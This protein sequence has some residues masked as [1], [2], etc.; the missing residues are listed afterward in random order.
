MRQRLLVL[1]ALFLPALLLVWKL[2]YAPFWNPDE[3][4]YSSASYEMAFGLDGQKPD[5]VVPHL[6]T[7]ARLN[8]PP[9]IYW[10]TATMFRVFGPSEIAGRLPSALAAIGVLLLLFLWGR[11]AFGTWIGVAGALVWTTSA[12]SFAMG[13]VANTDMLLTAS[14][15]LACFGIYWSIESRRK[16]LFGALAGVGMGL[17]LLAKGPVGLAM[18]LVVAALYLTI[19]KGW[20]KA[21]W[22]ALVVAL[23]L[24]IVIG[25]PWYLAVEAQ[26]PGFIKQFVFAE[27]LARFSGQEAY[28]KPTSKLF[29]LPILLVGMLP[30][31][32][33]LLVS[34]CHFEALSSREGRTKL[35]LVLWAGFITLFFSF[36]GT[37]L[38]SYILPAFPAL[39]L[40]VGASVA[41]CEFWP[42]AARNIGVT[43]T[44]LLNLILAVAVAFKP[45]VLTNDKLVPL[46]VGRPW[47]VALVAVMAVSSALLLL[48]A[49]RTDGKRIFAAQTVGGFLLLVLIVPLSGQ[50]GRYEDGSILFKKLK[51]YLRD[52]DRVGVYRTFLPSAVFYA[53]RPVTYFK[54]NNTSG[55]DK[56]ELARSPYFPG[57]E[58]FENFVKGPRTEGSPTNG[59]PTNGSPTNGSP[60]NGSPINRSSQR[61]F[62]ITDG[63][64]WP[65]VQYGLQLWGRN[66]D[67]FLY[68]TDAKPAEF[69]FSEHAGLKKEKKPKKP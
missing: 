63:P 69:D 61:A 55:L 9:L 53:E 26:R 15:A 64:I 32:G 42:R 12:L 57:S 20:K 56:E 44:L 65:P 58:D 23:G 21:P 36:S 14:I 45:G 67:W 18:P 13:R 2:D 16:L 35:F 68:S 51:P 46:A 19:I 1:L 27:N 10:T 60:T 7:V 39:A 52:T 24:A 38:A 30:W 3:G 28:H 37:K 34:P 4:R 33:F 59:S 6:D 40:F 8:K 5:W 31:T 49:R 11:A 22:G 54:F 48:A 50:I 17:A 47:A 66:N 29:Y 25:A 43:M 41:R 62:V